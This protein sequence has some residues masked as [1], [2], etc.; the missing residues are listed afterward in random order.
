MVTSSDSSKKLDYS[1]RDDEEEED[2]NDFH[3]STPPPDHSKHTHLTAEERAEIH[4][5][6]E[7][8]ALHSSSSL[9]DV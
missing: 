7:P 8:S 5:P 4:G 1:G 3:S 6:R 9:G 2:Y